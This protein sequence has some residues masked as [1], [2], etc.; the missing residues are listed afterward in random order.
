VANLRDLGGHDVRGG[1]QIASG[2]VFRSSHL[3][4]LS[5]AGEA[6][7]AGLGIGTAVDLR[8]AAERVVGEYQLPAGAEGVWLDVLA[9]SPDSAA[10]FAQL[11]G[12]GEL[13]RISAAD[14]EAFMLNSYRDMV[15]LPSARDAY[16][17]TFEIIA[18]PGSGVVLI[19]CTAG[20]DR[21]GWASAVLQLW[22]G[23]DE[24]AVRTE[25]LRSNEEQPE[26]IAELVAA[27]EAAGGDPAAVANLVTVRSDYLDLALA[28]LADRHGTVEGY[29]Q[30]GL[31]LSDETLQGLRDRLVLA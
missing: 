2:L 3:Q 29:L 7:L 31:G 25:Y 15:V 11:F 4:G 6:L 14:T 5:P 27:F 8:S 1:G 22:L 12:T 16:R 24:D 9:D 21:T 18:D 10:A 23:M 17:R 20:K 30:Q 13:H 19:H 28:Q 26:M